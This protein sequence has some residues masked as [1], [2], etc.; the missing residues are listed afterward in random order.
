MVQ[1]SEFKHNNLLIYTADKQFILSQNK[2]KQLRNS[3]K[4]HQIQLSDSNNK[5]SKVTYL[6]K[7]DKFLTLF[8]KFETEQSIIQLRKI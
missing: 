7:F 5:I 4:L 3:F 6:P 2:E 1:I 8:H